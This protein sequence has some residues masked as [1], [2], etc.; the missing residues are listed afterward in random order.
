MVLIFGDLVSHKGVDF[1]F[2]V[3]FAPSSFVL[4]RKVGEGHQES[5]QDSHDTFSF[6]SRSK[7]SGSLLAHFIVSAWKKANDGW[8]GQCWHQ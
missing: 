1:G 6:G 7:E 4:R 8:L 5:S 2:F 3:S